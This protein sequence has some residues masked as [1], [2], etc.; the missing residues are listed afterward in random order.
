MKQ[1]KS[2]G[3][4]PKATGGT[5]RGALRNSARRINQI[6]EEVI[7]PA[8]KLASIKECLKARYGLCT[9]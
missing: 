7:E 1:R 6:V 5:K 9:P 2:R 3:H 8:A 4:C